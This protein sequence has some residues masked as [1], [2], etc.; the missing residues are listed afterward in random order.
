MTYDQDSKMITAPKK[1]KPVLI[2]RVIR[3][4]KLQRIIVEEDR[5]G[6]CEGNVV[7]PLV[8]LVF[9]FIPFESDH[10]YIIIMFWLCD[11]P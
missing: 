7:F 2:R 8:Y 10:N 9:S 4:R 3:I 11:N 5:L 6:L 1:Q